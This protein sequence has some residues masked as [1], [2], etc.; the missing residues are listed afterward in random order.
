M[1]VTTQKQCDA[2]AEVR[3]SLDEEGYASDD[4]LY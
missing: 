4:M 3:K 2:Y 1:P